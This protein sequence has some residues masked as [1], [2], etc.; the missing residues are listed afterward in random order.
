MCHHVASLEWNQRS[1]HPGVDCQWTDNRKR[2]VPINGFIIFC[3]VF[4]HSKELK[5]YSC[6]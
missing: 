5:S 4:Q 6:F 3:D 2:K 1:F